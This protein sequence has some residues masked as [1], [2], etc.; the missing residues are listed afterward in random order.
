MF[1][2]EIYR[3]LTETVSSLVEKFKT[4]EINKTFLK[5]RITFWKYITNV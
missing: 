2:P 3:F 5:K 1:Y 4:M